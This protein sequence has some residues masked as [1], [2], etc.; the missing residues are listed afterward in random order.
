MKAPKPVGHFIACIPSLNMSGIPDIYIRCEAISYGD[1]T[2]M[3][4]S[5]IVNTI[6]PLNTKRV[7]LGVVPVQN[8]VIPSSVKM[9]YA[10][11]NELRYCDRASND[12]MRVLI[13]S[14]GIVV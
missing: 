1:I 2:F 10:Q 14:R 3:I 7:S 4:F 9:R 11:W 6:P 5:Y 12:C 13:T 8:L